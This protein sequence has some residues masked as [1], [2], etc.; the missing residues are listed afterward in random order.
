MKVRDLMS[1]DLEVVRPDTSYKRVVERMLA[2]NVSGLP[3]IDLHRRSLGE[4]Q[5]RCPTGQGFDHHQAERL[6]PPDGVQESSGT[7]EQPG[8]HRAAHLTDEHGVITQKW[9]HFDVEVPT[10]GHRPNLGGRHQPD[11][12]GTCR[13]DRSVRPFLGSHPPQKDDIAAVPST[14]RE[15]G[16]TP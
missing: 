11:S 5:Y 15:A 6:Y 3:V 4:R 14:D 9:A 13:H 8:L 16:S 10:L 7:A 2:R 12:R 1:T